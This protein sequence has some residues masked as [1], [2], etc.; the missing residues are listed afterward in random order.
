[1]LKKKTLKSA[2][3]KASDVG[4]CAGLLLQ[5]RWCDAHYE[6]READPDS[7][8]HPE[9]ARRPAG[10]PGTPLQGQSTREPLPQ[11][12]VDLLSCLLCAAQLQRADQRRDQLRLHA[13]LQRLHTAVCCVQRGR[14]QHAG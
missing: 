13:A 2:G 5:G 9:P 6:H 10:L 14:H 3:K 4:V 11:L 8:P 7:A 12:N 1:M